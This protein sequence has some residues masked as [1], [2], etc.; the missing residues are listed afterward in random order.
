MPF[1]SQCALLTPSRCPSSFTSCRSH[2]SQLHCAPLPLFPNISN[3]RYV[4][5]VRFLSV[6]GFEIIEFLC[7]RRWLAFA[8]S[9]SA[10]ITTAIYLLPSTHLTS[11]IFWRMLEADGVIQH[12]PKPL[13]AS[14]CRYQLDDSMPPAPSPRMWHLHLTSRTATPVRLVLVSSLQIIGQRGAGELLLVFLASP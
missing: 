1:L 2:A 14:G 10:S 13:S 7:L 11:M 4:R 12:R 6:G 5:C 8:A 3:L 9:R